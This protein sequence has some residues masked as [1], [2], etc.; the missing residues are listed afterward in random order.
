LQEEAKL[1]ASHAQH[2][3]AS[4][5]DKQR[6][7]AHLE[8]DIKAIKERAAH[9]ASMGKRQAKDLRA[10]QNALDRANALLEENQKQYA[11]LKMRA[12]HLAGADTQLQGL[13][14]ANGELRAANQALQTQL[15]ESEARNSD[16][17]LAR[18]QYLAEASDLVLLRSPLELTTWLCSAP[19]SRPWPLGKP[20]RWRG[21]RRLSKPKL[22][23]SWSR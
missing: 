7:A 14:D 4:G 8:K 12:K 10:K 18:D 2:L 1:A 11:E 21:W 5:I 15:R 23:S 20:P 6:R 19:S 9:L 13:R 3:A 16:G 17:D 22:T